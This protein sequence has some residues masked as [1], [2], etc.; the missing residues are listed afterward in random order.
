[1]SQGSFWGPIRRTKVVWGG[2][3]VDLFGT[4]GLRI[5]AAHEKAQSLG[6]RVPL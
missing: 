6:V 2:I 4:T 5:W 1:M 3:Q